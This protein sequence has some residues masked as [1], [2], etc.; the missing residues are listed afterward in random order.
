MLYKFNQ[1]PAPG[2]YEDGFITTSGV[3]NRIP[4]VKTRKKIITAQGGQFS[5]GN[6]YGNFSGG[7]DSGFGGMG[8][9]SSAANQDRYNPVRDRLDEGSVVEDWIPRDASGLDQMFRLM[10]HRDH[11]AGTIVDLLS[12]II[13]SEYDLSGVKDPTILKIYQDTL[14][15]LDLT[16]LLPDMTREYLVLGRSIS[17]M[18]FDEQRG[19]FR[20]IVSHDPSLVRLTPIPLKG[21]DPKIDLFPSPA[22]RAFVESADPRDSDAKKML[23][24]AFVAAIKNMT[25]GS[26]GVASGIGGGGPNFQASQSLLYGPHSSTVGSSG[27]AL[28]PIN[29]LFVA[30][31]VF[32][33]DRIGTSLFTRLI[34]FWA[35]E[36]ALINATVSSARRRSR[37]ILHIKMGIDNIWEPS[38]AEM[39]NTAGMF[40]QADEDPVGAVVVTRNGV[41]ANEIRQGSDFYKW[42]D[43]WQLLNEGKLRALGANDALLSGEATYSNQDSARQFFME[44]ALNLRHM[45]TYRIFYKKLFLLTARV[46]GFRKIPEAHLAHGIRIKGNDDKLTQREALSIPEDDLIIPTI[47]WNK[48][49]VNQVNTNKMEILD[50]AEAKGIPVSLKVWANAANL[51]LGALISDMENDG[52]L[53]KQIAV[54]RSKFEDVSGQEEREAKLEFVNSLRKISH[55][56]VQQAVGSTGKA[57]GPI[58]E[59][60][61]WGPNV[62][63]GNLTAKKLSDFLATFQTEGELRRLAEPI[64]F[65][66]KLM[67]FFQHKI[68]A[69]VAH[70][71]MHRYA[72]TPVLPSLCSDAQEAIAANVNMVL[73]QY[74]AH[75]NRYQLGKVATAELSAVSALGA[76]EQ[77]FEAQALVDSAQVKTNN[78]DPLTSASP[79]LYSGKPG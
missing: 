77:A 56:Q 40:I 44:R 38:P 55:S 18:I 79:H 53:R 60:I 6:D 43:E 21:F 8:A 75:V 50:Q 28:D 23:P 2:L 15:A 63:I 12:E 22:L 52:D 11:I 19:I 35:L 1:H 45:L 41:D 31:K 17:S 70:Y 16:S 5:S 54:W 10:Y 26:S 7:G 30:R 46:H 36:K 61:F 34:T 71:L 73:S 25:G 39:D 72:I 3:N 48:E 74:A 42:S 65:K 59:Y 33:Y 64:D 27:I 14:N 58:S 47:H 57:L 20:D 32:N 24:E 13:W 62:K 76:K 66:T 68:D 49:L 37:S 67:A 29:T 51:D 4:S 9:G 69:D 78:L